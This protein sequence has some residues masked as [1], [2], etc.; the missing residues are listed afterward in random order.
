M[1]SLARALNYGMIVFFI[2]MSSQGAAIAGI[3][4]RADIAYNEG[5]YL[6]AMELWQS[7]AK[8]EFPRAQYN[9]GKMYCFGEGV[10]TNQNEGRKW[11]RKAADQ[12][13]TRAQF[14]LGNIHYYGD[15]VDENLEKAISWY[16]KAADQG[17]ARAQFVLGLM[18]RLGEGVEKN[19]IQAYKWWGLAAN[20]GHEDA[21]SNKSDVRKLMTRNEIVRAKLLLKNWRVKPH[22]VIQ[23]KPD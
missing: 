1:L 17:F 10:R 20:Q 4:E 3:F 8:Q 2:V 19:N 14:N 6:K 16:R 12:G 5:D 11:W 23:S 15:G 7:L 9:L 13:H 21:I 22:K 18:Y